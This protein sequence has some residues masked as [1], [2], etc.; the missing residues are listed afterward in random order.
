MNDSHYAFNLPKAPTPKIYR[1]TQN[2]YEDLS[3]ISIQLSRKIQPEDPLTFFSILFHFFIASL[4]C[5]SV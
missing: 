5:S 1:E 3:N 4:I 2:S